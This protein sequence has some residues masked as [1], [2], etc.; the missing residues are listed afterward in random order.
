MPRAYAHSVVE[1]CV[2]FLI[3]VKAS[4]WNRYGLCGVRVCVRVFVYLFGCA[5]MYELYACLG[6]SC[7]YEKKKNRMR[8]GLPF[9]TSNNNR[10]EHTIC[11]VY[12]ILFWYYTTIFRNVFSEC[13]N[14]LRKKKNIWKNWICLC[15]KQQIK[16]KQ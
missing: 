10:T 2:I 7:W 14:I 16:T 11:L 6:V 4:V 3:K 13:I 15:G 8:W 1:I 9:A 5:C 12:L